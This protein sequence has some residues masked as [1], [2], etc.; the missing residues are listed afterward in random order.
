MKKFILAAAALLIGAT[1]LADGPKTCRVS[2]T[3]GSVV[4]NAYVT[5]SSTGTCEVTLSNDTDENVNVTY[6]LSGTQSNGWAAGSITRSRLVYANSEDVME[7]SFNKEV[8]KVTV[9][10]VSGT[11]CE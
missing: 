7:V 6:T 9:S 11:K 2:G 5:D 3:T 1:A 8:S 4:V 10:S